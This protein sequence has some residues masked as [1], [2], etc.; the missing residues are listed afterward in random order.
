MILIL[1]MAAAMLAAPQQPPAAA[2]SY[3]IHAELA[4][5]VTTATAKPG[6]EV[7]FE[8]LDDAKAA[9]GS[10]VIP[11]KA[12]LTGRVAQVVKR[13]DAMPQAQL[14]IV[15]EKA[16]W[17]NKSLALHAFPVTLESVGEEA[18]KRAAPAE[19]T[20][21]MGSTSS[22]RNPGLEQPPWMTSGSSSSAGRIQVP[23][24]KDCG[25]EKADDP[26]LGSVLVCDQQQ[27]ALGPGARL[28]LRAQSR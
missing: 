14:S 13:T 17:K 11:K 19:R 28:I 16:E 27:V 5:P 1:M 23:V 10:V 7:R 15:V 26:A 24:P 9:D 25:L 4:N 18:A 20:D 21:P 2:T 22:P 6:D 8:V 12:K 3:R